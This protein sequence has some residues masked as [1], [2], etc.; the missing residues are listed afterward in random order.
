MLCARLRDTIIQGQSVDQAAYRKGFSTVDHLLSTTLLIEAC[1]E[2]QVP[3]WMGMV[4]FE[5]AFDTV[6]HDT[7]WKS[8]SEHGV[9]PPY[10]NLLKR[11]YV[12]QGATVVAGE[13]SRVFD[14]SCG[15]KQGDP[16][17]SFL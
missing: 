5:K 10:I 6:E 4:D 3:L 1:N 16:I 8:L 15:V 11:L 17:S 12:R 14:I 9:Q 13:R 2:F 7:L